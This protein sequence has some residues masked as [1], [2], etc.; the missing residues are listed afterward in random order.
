MNGFNYYTPPEYQ[1]QNSIISYA[2]GRDGI[3]MKEV[4]PCGATTWHIAD[5]DALQGEFQPWNEAPDVDDS[6][7][8]RLKKEPS[9]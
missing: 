7:W 4:S 8:S 5:W 9:E 6:D 2:G 3:Y 1:G